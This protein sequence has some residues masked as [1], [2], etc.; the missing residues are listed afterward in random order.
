MQV[1][2]NMNPVIDRIYCSGNQQGASQF[3]YFANVITV[4]KPRKKSWQ[5][6]TWGNKRMNLGV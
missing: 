5:H 6:L 1:L 3:A 4:I 2:Q